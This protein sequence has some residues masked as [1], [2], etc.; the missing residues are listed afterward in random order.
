MN[1]YNVNGH[2]INALQYVMLKNASKAKFLPSNDT[3]ENAVPLHVNPLIQEL[4]AGNTAEILHDATD[5]AKKGFL[6]LRTGAGKALFAEATEKGNIINQPSTTPLRVGYHRPAVSNANN[7]AQEMPDIMKNALQTLA[8]TPLVLNEEMRKLVQRTRMNGWTPEERAVIKGLLEWEGPIY[9]EAFCDWRGR[10]YNQSGT[11]GSY[12]QS[13][14]NRAMLDAPEATPVKYG[15]REYKYM[16]TITEC[17]YGV[18]DKNWRQILNKPITEPSDLN[19]ARAALAIKEVKETGK[20]AYMMEQDASCSGAQF[21]ALLMGDTKMAKYTNLLPDSVKHDL[22]TFIAA[23]TTI[24]ELLNNVGITNP[25]KIR[26]AAKPVVMLSFY[27]SYHKQI[28]LN[29]WIDNEGEM[30]ENSNDEEVPSKTATIK[31]LGGTWN[32]ETLE[33]YTNVAQSKLTAEFPTF[34]D[35]KG[36]MAAWFS[37]IHDEDSTYFPIEWVTPN[38]WL[39]ERNRTGEDAGG[40]MPNFVHSLDAAVVHRVINQ[41]AEEGITIKT[42]HDAFFTTPTNALRLREIVAQCY[43]S[44]I[45]DTSNPYTGTKHGYTQDFNYNNTMLDN[46]KDSTLIG[47]VFI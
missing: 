40:T 27:G 25:K 2:D 3:I 44:V 43:A 20:T 22:Y 8:D 10:A 1:Y 29:I 17:E 28:A 41:C 37:N 7:N 16:I 39:I 26:N 14:I 31:W 19:R 24:I 13:K 33:Y 45:R 4:Y 9:S 18:N 46:L 11:F 36:R 42:V 6:T 23:D 38:G 32:F 12:T 5:L 15:S 47:E 35:F 21:V 34:G 30:V